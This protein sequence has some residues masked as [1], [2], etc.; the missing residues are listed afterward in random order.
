MICGVLQPSAGSLRMLGKDGRAL[1]ELQRRRLGYCPQRLVIWSDLTGH[2][3]LSFMA[4][5][6]GM[7]RA[8]AENRAAT[9]LEVLGLQDVRHRLAAKLSGGMKRRLNVALAMVHDPDLLVLDEPTE[10]LDPQSRLLVRQVLRDCVHLGDKTILI[11]THDMD[12]A[13]RLAHRV[14]I[15]DHGRLMALDTPDGLKACGGNCG[16]VEIILLGQGAAILERAAE[17]LAPLTTRVLRSEDRLVLPG[18]QQDL[19]GPVRERLA[20]AAIEPTEIRFRRRTLEDV[21][22]ELTGRRLRR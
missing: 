8:T 3:Q 22:I 15:I 6:Y 13:E 18:E 16:V 2:E 1:R 17:A 20:A 14:A 5:M 4:R 12:E 21:F 7:D 10:G 9:L 11:S 19:A